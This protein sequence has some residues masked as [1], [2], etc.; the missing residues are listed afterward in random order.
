MRAHVLKWGNSLAV[1]IPKRIA[2]EASLKVGDR[3]EIE[4]PDQGS[5]RRRRVG[6]SLTP[7]ELVAQITPDNRYPEISAGQQAGKEDFEW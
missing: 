5:V 7:V 6:K 2:E 3:L 4:V 1:R